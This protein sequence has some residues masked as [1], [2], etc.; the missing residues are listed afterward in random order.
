[1]ITAEGFI[2][3]VNSLFQCKQMKLKTICSSISNYWDKILVR[4][5]RI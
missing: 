4:L 2:L 3:I 5:L 1:M